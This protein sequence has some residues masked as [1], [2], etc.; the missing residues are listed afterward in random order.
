MAAQVLTRELRQQDFRC[1]RGCAHEL[2]AVEFH[3]VITVVLVQREPPAIGRDH[4]SESAKGLHS[5]PNHSSAHC[6]QW[7]GAVKGAGRGSRDRLS[8]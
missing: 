1:R 5:V 7:D 8:S 6:Q 2:A 4:F 3:E